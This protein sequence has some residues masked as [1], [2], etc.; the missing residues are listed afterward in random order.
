MVH[1]KRNRARGRRNPRRS[2]EAED[3]G[4]PVLGAEELLRFARIKEMLQAGS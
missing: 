4:H 1:S 2:S 3:L